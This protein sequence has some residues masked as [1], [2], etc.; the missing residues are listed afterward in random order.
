MSSLLQARTVD[1]IP[2]WEPN[3]DP[4]LASR[5]FAAGVRF[6]GGREKTR[7]A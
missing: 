4:I 7:Q 2:G 5:Y 1:L 6:V 3:V